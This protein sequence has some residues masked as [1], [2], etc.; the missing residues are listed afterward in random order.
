M[1]SPLIRYLLAAG[2]ALVLT[3]ATHAQE[4]AII[5]KARARIGSESAINGVKSI[6]YVGTLITVDPADPTKQQR[7]AIDIIFQKN[8][9]QR[10]TAAFD[11]LVETTALDGY[12][13]WQRKQDAADPSKWQQTLLGPDQVKRLRAN[14]F[15]TLAFFRGLESRGGRIED[16]GPA[17]VEGV[18]CQKVSF[19]HGANIIFT[20]YFD[21][22]TGKLV[23]TETETGNTLREQGEILEAGLRFPKSLLTTTTNAQGENQTV[24]INVEKVIVNETYPATLFGVPALSNK[25]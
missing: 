7:A 18:A 25:K 24:T 22:T 5:A 11:K 17:T 2:N 20:R 10:I 23:L 12:E 21:L 1:W 4:L 15:E 13:A 9:L 3:V 6:H 8:D 19:V 16:K 14:T